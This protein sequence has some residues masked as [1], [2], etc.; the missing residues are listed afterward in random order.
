MC[1]IQT[2]VLRAAAGYAYAAAM[3]AVPCGA[4]VVCAAA[5]GWPGR[6]QAV[7]GGPLLLFV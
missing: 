3:N 2:F 1:V 7:A 5:G 4:S 6:C